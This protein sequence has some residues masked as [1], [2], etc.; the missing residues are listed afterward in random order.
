M[1]F[2]HVILLKRTKKRE[3]SSIMMREYK[4]L[5]SKENYIKILKKGLFVPVIIFVSLFGTLELKA[6]NITVDTYYD[7]NTTGQCSLR[8]AILAANTDTEVEGCVA[9][10]SGL[11]T[12]MLKGGTYVMDDNFPKI[13]D[14]LE[15]IGQDN[16]LGKPVFTRIKAFN[17][18]VSSNPP[19]YQ[20]FYFRPLASSGK[21]LLLKGLYLNKGYANARPGLTGGGCVSI[22][23]S[24][25]V[26]LDHVTLKYCGGTFGGGLSYTSS[27]SYTG[28]I[29]T[30]NIKWSIIRDNSAYEG[31]GISLFDSVN[32]NMENTQIVYNTAATKGGGMMSKANESTF[33][34]S[35]QYNITRTLVRYN[36]AGGI[37]GSY[38]DV[39]LGAGIYINNILPASGNSAYH[40]VSLDVDIS[41]STIKNNVLSGSASGAGGQGVGMFMSGGSN[42]SVNLFNTQ[43]YNNPVYKGSSYAYEESFYAQ[44]SEVLTSSGYNAIGNGFI[45]SGSTPWTSP[46]APAG[47]PNT[48]NDYVLLPYSYT[49]TSF[50][51]IDKG[52]CPNEQF[53]VHGNALNSSQRAVGNGCDI[54]AVESGAVP[55]VDYDADG[56]LDGNDTFPFDPNESVDTDGDY[57][58]NNADTDDDND[59]VLDVDDAFSLDATESVDTDGD[60]IGNNADTDDDD[61]GVLD[62]DDAFPLDASEYLDT[63]NDGIGNKA[64][65]DD[66]NDGI[67]DSDET[68]LGFDPLDA[69]STPLDTDGDGS[70]DALDSDDDNDGI[71]DSDEA[72]LG[73]NPI[74][75]SDGLAD[76]DGDGFSNVLEFSIGTNMNDTN[77]KPI[78]TPIIMDNIMIFIPAKP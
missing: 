16:N 67:S 30:L 6:A 76:S 43:L 14:S 18:V 71:S 47:T 20:I 8:S 24:H 36:A 64:D 40:Q 27:A 54:G 63:D 70:P 72:T 23:G 31:G 17:P 61:D 22:H 32:L 73:F 57:I 41:H 13:T 66:D 15:V 38:P 51:A 42:L 5:L 68:T 69:S 65:T 74:N 34:L 53:D 60:G 62:V 2:L 3:R 29:G 9:G 12:I 11:D 44:S 77:D 55:V 58:G 45:P 49:D 35:S 28:N 4:I 52:Y 33:L 19:S 46:F 21:T 59:G 78:W 37:A 56:V 75:A 10:S 1:L 25:D 26:T 39:P 50:S 7:L 48:N